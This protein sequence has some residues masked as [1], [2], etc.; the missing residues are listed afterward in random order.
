MGLWSESRVQTTLIS[1]VYS[2]RILVVGKVRL[3]N[4]QLSQPS[5]GQIDAAF[6]NHREA[7]ENP[8][9]SMLPSR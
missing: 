9:S 1:A 2:F 6:L 3:C 7:P 5:P 8:R 4:T